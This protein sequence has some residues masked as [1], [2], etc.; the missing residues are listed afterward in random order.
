MVEALPSFAAAAPF[1]FAAR[2]YRLFPPLWLTQGATV[3][4][5]CRMA[6]ETFLH[7]SPLVEYRVLIILRVDLS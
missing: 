5:A 3:C 1:P 6:S 4:I 2:L 7:D